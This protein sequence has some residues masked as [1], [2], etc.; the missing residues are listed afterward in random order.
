MA[1]QHYRFTLRR[2]AR[3][4]PYGPWTTEINTT[5]DSYHVVGMMVAAAE[6]ISEDDPAAREQFRRLLV[7][8]LERMG[9]DTTKR[10]L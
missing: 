9:K 1:R 5:E 10:R 7:T 3:Y 2:A 6:T 8:T 4:G